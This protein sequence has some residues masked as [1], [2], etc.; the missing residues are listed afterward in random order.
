MNR[1]RSVAPA[2]LALT[3]LLALSLARPGRSRANETVQGLV[4]VAAGWTDNVLAR[5]TREQDA[6]FQLRPG[7]VFTSGGARGVQQ[8]GDTFSADLFALHSNGN[9]YSNRLYWTGLFLLSP[10]TQLFTQVDSNVGKLNTLNSLSDSSAAVTGVLPPGG[11]VFFDT[12]AREN[13]YW[14]V[15][16]EWRANQAG[17]FRVFVPL[18]PS[19]ASP[20]TWDGV[21]SLGTERLFRRDSVGIDFRTEYIQYDELRDSQTNA[22][23]TPFQRQLVLSLLPRWRRDWSAFWSSELAAGA[24]LAFRAEDGSGLLVE[25]V[26]LAAIRYIRLQL[27]GELAYAH[28][29]TANPYAGQTFAVDEVALRALFRFPERT[30]VAFGATCSYQHARAVDA[31][32]GAALASFDVLLADATVTWQP[33]PE[34][35]VFLRYQFFDQFA[36]TPEQSFYRNNVMV[37]VSAI[38]PATA[39]VA[40]PQRPGQRVDRSDMSIPEPHSPPP[41]EK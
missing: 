6:V 5:P 28:N 29:V 17:S 24:L 11:T 32:P 2:T 34:I 9:S 25:P 26:G 30:H 14:T 22:V 10:K 13:F 15:D 7:V 12:T 39:A 37:G 35:G 36:P 3:T 4:T 33:R 21:L 1:S 40:V 8:L 38:Y 18:V 41:P 20:V 27:T 16:K 19:N 23:I 31:L